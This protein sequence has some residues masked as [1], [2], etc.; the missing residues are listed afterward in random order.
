MTTVIIYCL[1]FIKLG[2]VE[3]TCMITVKE[4]FIAKVLAAKYCACSKIM[5]CE[6]FASSNNVKNIVSHAA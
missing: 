1:Q 4:D 3:G 6:S 5:A 2:S